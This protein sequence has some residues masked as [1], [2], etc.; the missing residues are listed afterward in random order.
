MPCWLG[1]GWE[2]LACGEGFKRLSAN[3]KHATPQERK[4]EK[5]KGEGQVVISV[6]VGWGGD[7]K[8]SVWHVERVLR[9]FQ[10]RGCK[11]IAQRERGNRRR[12]RDR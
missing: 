12:K 10:P 3:R 8:G 6:H 9:D 2:S 11:S 7:R 4:G 1:R 5:K